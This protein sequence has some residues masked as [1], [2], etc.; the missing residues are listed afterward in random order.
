MAFK[1]KPDATFTATVLIPNG[2]QPLPLKLKF[3]RKRK[4]DVAA[5]IESAAGRADTDTLGEVIDGWIEVDTP[6]SAEA[7]AELLAAYSGAGM[8]IFGGYLRALSEAERKN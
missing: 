6:Y 3:R 1:L 2:D 4:E 7:L 8:A 5:W